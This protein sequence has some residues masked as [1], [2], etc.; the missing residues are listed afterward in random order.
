LG[1]GLVSGFVNEDNDKDDVIGLGTLD[2]KMSKVHDQLSGTII[3]LD[4]ELD[5]RAQIDQ[6][7]DES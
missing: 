3:G 5:I 4:E 1:L 6:E 7:I 2:N